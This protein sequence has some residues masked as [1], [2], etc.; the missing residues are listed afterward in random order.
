LDK[1]FVGDAAA[2]R[3]LFYR[4]L[5]Q[6]VTTQLKSAPPAEQEKLED[7]FFQFTTALTANPDVLDDNTLMWA[8]QQNLSIAEAALKRGEAGKPKAKEFSKSA[9]GLYKLLI[10]RRTAALAPAAAAKK[11]A[12][13]AIPPNKEAVEQAAA[14]LERVENDIAVLTVALGRA[15]RL[16]QDYQA[17]FDTLVPLLQK[18]ENILEGQIEICDTLLDWGETG[19]LAKF[20]L[21][22]NG[23]KQRNGK[24]PIWGLARLRNALKPFV[25][26][27]DG[28]AEDAREKRL[29]RRE[30]FFE[31]DLAFTKSLLTQG[32]HPSMPAAQKKRYLEAGPKNIAGLVNL[33]GKELESSKEWYGAYDAL[34]KEFQRALGEQPT[35]IKGLA[36]P[37]NGT[38]AN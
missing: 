20:N 5:G 17:A 19:D 1:L 27:P 11:A 14:A 29:G 33:F 10:T 6:E 35:G 36:K 13:A 8:G 7:T 31:C 24:Q 34:L 30:K 32:Q 26:A 15:Q 28:E 23:I 3:P 38:A 9:E 37:S 18:H 16:G 4:Q 12:E 25:T 22:R 2:E 21:A